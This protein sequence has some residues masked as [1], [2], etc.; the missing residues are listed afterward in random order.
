MKCETFGIKNVN[1]MAVQYTPKLITNNADVP[2]VGM[3][4]GSLI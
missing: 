4:E 2:P 1:T 3:N